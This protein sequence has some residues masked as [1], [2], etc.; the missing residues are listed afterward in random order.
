MYI[1]VKGGMSTLRALPRTQEKET[2]GSNSHF[3]TRKPHLN[4]RL[5]ND[6]PWPCMGWHHGGRRA[7]CN[8]TLGRRHEVAAGGPRAKEDGRVLARLPWSCRAIVPGRRWKVPKEVVHGRVTFY[9]LLKYNLLLL[10]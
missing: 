2:G 10:L 9:G 3:Y 6:S 4:G 8:G 5:S 7:C 1:H